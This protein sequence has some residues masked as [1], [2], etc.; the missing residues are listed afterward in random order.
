MALYVEIARRSPGQSTWETLGSAEL[1][2]DNV[3]LE[4]LS[5]PEGSLAPG[6]LDLIGRTIARDRKPHPEEEL[7]DQLG[8]VTVSGVEYRYK[9][10]FA[11]PQ[12]PGG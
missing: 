11:N 7:A 5:I 4:N 3:T 1:C 2:A 9:T 12:V 6:A 10:V 8:T